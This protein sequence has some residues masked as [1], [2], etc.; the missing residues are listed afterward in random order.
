MSVSA[1]QKFKL[2]K[3]QYDIP[4]DEE[5]MV[6][7]LLELEEE[8]ESISKTSNTIMTR[9]TLL[10]TISR[11][12]AS[13]RLIPKTVESNYNILFIGN[14]NTQLSNIMEQVEAIVG[15]NNISA[16]TKTSKQLSL[17]TTYGTTI[18]FASKSNIEQFKGMRIDYYFNL[19]ENYE[20]EDKF[21]RP[22]LF[23]QAYKT[24]GE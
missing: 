19:S 3:E 14:V 7:T 6:K 20:F 2:W 15:K 21:I 9:K 12:K 18:Y 5:F 16:K 22:I 10:E 4:Y 1:E 13:L 17:K 11:L 24:K 8:Y 23:P